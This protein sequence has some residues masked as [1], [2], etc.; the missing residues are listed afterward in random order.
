MDTHMKTLLLGFLILSPDNS[1]T[2]IHET[3][4]VWACNAYAQ[5]IAS[6]HGLEVVKLAVGETLPV[7]ITSYAARMSRT[8][9][10][11]CVPLDADGL[12]DLPSDLTD[13]T[14]VPH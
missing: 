6:F 14:G 2:V 1:Q 5:Q 11:K 8:F 7:G 10:Y 12:P 3:P 13:E 4:S 9:R